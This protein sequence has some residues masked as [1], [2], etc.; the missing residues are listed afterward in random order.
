MSSTSTYKRV[1]NLSRKR[2]R[3]N[4][5]YI[6]NAYQCVKFPE[7]NTCKKIKEKSDE[8]VMRKY[9]KTSN[10]NTTDTSNKHFNVTSDASQFAKGMRKPNRT[11]PFGFHFLTGKRRK[12]SLSTMHHCYALKNR[13]KMDESKANRNEE[14]KK[15]EKLKDE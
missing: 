12:F 4:L 5:K 9:S 10:E 2:I 8:N 15:K 7:F 11:E 13:R 6:L 1:K 14:K 3:M